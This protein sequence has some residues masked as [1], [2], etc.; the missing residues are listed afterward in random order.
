MADKQENSLGKTHTF[1]VPKLLDGN[2]KRLEALCK[3]NG[4]TIGAVIN[5][6]IYVCIGDLEK[7]VPNKRTITLNGKEV[8]L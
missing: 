6:M 8:V 2:W 1:Y 7:Q 3:Q 4:L 5:A